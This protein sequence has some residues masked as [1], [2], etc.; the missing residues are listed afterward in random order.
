MAEKVE[1]IFLERYG[2]DC[3]ACKHWNEIEHPGFDETITCEACGNEFA[4]TFDLYLEEFNGYK[5]VL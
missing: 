4:W 1:L 5:Y 3:P 2:F